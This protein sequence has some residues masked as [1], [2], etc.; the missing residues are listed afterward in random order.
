VFLMGNMCICRE[1]QD[2]WIVCVNMLDVTR[3]VDAA[4]RTDMPRVLT[5]QLRDST[6]KRGHTISGDINL[7]FTE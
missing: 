3:P 5:T 7:I 2:D 1:Q 4:A 6:I